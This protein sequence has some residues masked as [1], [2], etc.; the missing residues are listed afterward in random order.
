[1]ILYINYHLAN[2]HRKGEFCHTFLKLV[3]LVK[4]RIVDMSA[5]QR[6]LEAP[7][8]AAAIGLL[9]RLCQTVD[10]LDKKT[11]WQQ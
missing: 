4:K 10:G 1:M 7:H 6:E 5:V 8:R 3:H 2:P 11:V 9:S